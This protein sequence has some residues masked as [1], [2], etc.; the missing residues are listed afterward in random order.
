MRATGPGKER[1]RGPVADRASSLAQPRGCSSSGGPA[2][3]SS[4]PARSPG[5]LVSR[6]RTRSPGAR[7]DR[8]RCPPGSAPEASAGRTGSRRTSATRRSISSSTRPIRTRRRCPRTR[9]SPA[10]A[11]R[12]RGS[13]SHRPALDPR[14]PGPVDGRP[15]RRARGP[16]ASRP[17][18]AGAP[19][20]RKPGARS[21]HRGESGRVRGARGRAP[22]H[23]ARSGPLSRSS[24]RAGRSTSKPNA[25]CSNRGRSTS[26]CRRTAGGRP[27]MQSWRRPARSGLPV[28][29]IARPP[30]PPG[31]RVESAAAAEAWI[32]AHLGR[33]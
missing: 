17:R 10:N 32:E 21:V 6:R 28:V 22:L 4:L 16:R 8:L 31:E 12:R 27:R 18:D 1:R 25:A 13:S 14:A 15:G 9:P 23:R 3:R 30:P 26:S 7:G 2:R 29:M 20:R 33:R 11:H 5:I 19:H 24:S